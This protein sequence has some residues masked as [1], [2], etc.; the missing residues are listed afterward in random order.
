MSKRSGVPLTGMT[1]LV[2]FAEG[3]LQA[4]RK[5]D[6]LLMPPAW[7]IAIVEEF[8]HDPVALFVAELCSA[9]TV[10]S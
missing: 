3:G 5:H 2:E 8:V 9:L 4:S 1:W 7:L 6:A 10:T